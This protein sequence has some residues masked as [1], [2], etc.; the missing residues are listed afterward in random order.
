MKANIIMSFAFSRLTKRNLLNTF[1][2]K[3]FAN[4]IFITLLI[5]NL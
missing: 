1:L 5:L 2:N 4:N 3:F